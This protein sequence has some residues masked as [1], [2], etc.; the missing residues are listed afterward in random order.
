M[1]H[2]PLY[3]RPFVPLVKRRYGDHLRA[4]IESRLQGRL[5]VPAVHSVSGVVVVPRSDAGVNVTRSHAGDEKE[6]VPVAK[7]LDGLPVLVRGA[8]GEAVGGKIG[9]HAVKA[10]CQDVVLVTLLHDQS[11]ENRV[12]SRIPHAVGSSGG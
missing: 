8:E 4:H 9:V 2:G 3:L 10:T 12:V 1:G 7:R 6:V 11:D 5:V